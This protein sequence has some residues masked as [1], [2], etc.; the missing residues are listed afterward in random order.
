MNLAI[1]ETTINEILQP[2]ELVPDLEAQI[3]NQLQ[4]LLASERRAGYEARDREVREKTEAF[5]AS[6][7]RQSDKMLID[8]LSTHL[9]SKV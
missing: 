7:P 3:V 9:N 4:D 1:I 5:R 2:A 6:L 8:E